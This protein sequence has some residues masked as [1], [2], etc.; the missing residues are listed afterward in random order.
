M[1]WPQGKRNQDEQKKKKKSSIQDKSMMNYLT[2]ISKVD[3]LI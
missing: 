1:K 2:K 3:Q